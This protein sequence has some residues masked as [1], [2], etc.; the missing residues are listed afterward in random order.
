[1]KILR[2]DILLNDVTYLLDNV[3]EIEPPQPVLFKRNH[4]L[5][6]LETFLDYFE[7]ELW[8]KLVKIVNRNICVSLSSNSPSR[9]SKHMCTTDELIRFYSYIIFIE[10]TYGNS[11][12]NLRKHHQEI[13]EKEGKING[14]E[15][16]RFKQLWRSFNP[17][18]EELQDIINILNK[19]FNKFISLITTVTLDES[20]IEYQP[21][22]TKKAQCIKNGEPIP[23]VYIPRKP[24]PNGLK[25]YTLATY[26]NHP[27]KPGKK[28]PYIVDIKPHL[29]ANDCT[30][31]ELIT[32]FITKWNFPTKFH[33]TGDSGFGNIEIID[34]LIKFGAKFTLS[35]PN[36]T[37][38]YLWEVLTHSTVPN[39]WR[40]AIN[41]KQFI[42]S[43]HTLENEKRA[44]IYKQILSNNFTTSIIN[45]NLVE[46]SNTIIENNMSNY[47]S[48]VLKEKKVAELQHI[49]KLY[50]ITSKC[51]LFLKNWTNL[52]MKN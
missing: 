33:L 30:S 46:S 9:W 43:A 49:I 39:S 29:T 40:A 24:H 34:E 32:Y 5:T 16:D 42:A 45:E 11:V 35:I 37:D 22:K 19:I 8:E 52:L 23:V 13:K 31:K 41:N 12:H 10:N 1:M 27:S 28:I 17:T 51:K 2:F 3:S 21:D 48:E 14:L 15:I 50:N 20:M 4:K 6:L 38:T 44:I 25:L 36:T 47:T 18:I 7:P 26:I